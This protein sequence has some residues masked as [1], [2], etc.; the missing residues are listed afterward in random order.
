MP[1]ALAVVACTDTNPLPD[2]AP[3]FT[4]PAIVRAGSPIQVR[5]PA[6]DGALL[7]LGTLPA[8]PLTIGHGTK[9]T[10]ANGNVSAAAHLA[11]GAVLKTACLRRLAAD[12]DVCVPIVAQWTELL[13][14]RPVSVAV[15]P[16]GVLLG[17]VVTV[18]ADDLLLPGEGTAVVQVE[19]AP[20]SSP[21]DVPIATDLATGR[22]VGHIVAAATWLGVRPKVWAVRYR[23]VQTVPKTQAVGPWTGPEQVQ[24]LP[25][26]IVQGTEID[27][28][29]GA[30]L[31][32]EL[33]GLAATG[34]Q[35]EFFG[36][37]AGP[38]TRRTWT[39]EKPV[40]IAGEHYLGKPQ[41]V[42]RSPWFLAQFGG[43]ISLVGESAAF[44]GHVRVLLQ[45][46]PEPWR[47][48]PV[49]IQLQLAPTLQAIVIEMGGDFEAGLV[50]FGLANHA[51]TL[52]K[53]I[54]QEVQLGFA[55]LHVAVGQSAPP[56]QVESLHLEII[57]ADPSHQSLLGNDNS[58][59]KDVG[60]LV[61][62]E[63]IAGFNQAT[64]NRGRV[65]FGGVF[66]HS[67][68]HFSRKLHVDGPVASPDFDAI[69]GPYAPA[70]GGKAAPLAKPPEAALDTFAKLIAETVV[71][72]V[73]HALGLAAG[74]ELYHHLGDNPGWRMDTGIY[75]Q[76][77]ER[78]ALPGAFP[79]IW[80]PLDLQYL[81]KILPVQ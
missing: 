77:A 56:G 65:G 68:L 53:R 5:G 17:A 67:F 14:S 9:A 51:E 80:G 45:D 22:T 34:W 73:G 27:V 23:L 36:T 42:A 48:A 74:T 30:V 79:K 72:E 78:V 43:L 63:D 54:V 81:Q 4:I 8:I 29:R 13:G 55:G 1:L 61:L 6:L 66:L 60:N 21:V 32:L 57:A 2:P 20:Q 59:G 58:T 64:A 11:Q 76:F 19:L 10:I 49:P 35:L 28:R 44:D 12:H 38:R 7:H 16:D 46:G 62:D 33:A 15:P 37:W 50:E 26:T 18:T 41:A 40:V 47:G 24:L 39:A 71:H 69:F 25:P 52:R 3:Q 31:P 70:L 75:R